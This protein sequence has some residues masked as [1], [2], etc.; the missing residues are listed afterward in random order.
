MAKKDHY[1]LLL[2][3]DL[4]NSLGPAQ[5]YTKINLKNAYH[6]VCIAEGDKP[7]TAFCTQYR[8]Y[9]WQ[10]MPFGLRNALV[11]FQRFINDILGDLLDICTM[12]YLDDILIYSESLDAHKDHVRE[13]LHQLRKV[14]LYMNPKKCKFHTDTVEYLGFI[15]SPEGLIMDPS[16]VSAIQ[17][18]LE[19]YNIQDIQSFLGFANFYC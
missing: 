16:K 2:I 11:A 7:K 9:E 12:G 5:I 17:D 14:G 8:S 4:M 10:V 6:L 15:L 3:L 13:V 19:P 18:W 1:L